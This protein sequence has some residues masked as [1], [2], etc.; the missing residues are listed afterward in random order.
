MKV[1]KEK[2][3]NDLLEV[4]KEEWNDRR[5]KVITKGTHKNMGLI[6]IRT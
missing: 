1:V 6:Q 2:E 4:D 3:V 5:K